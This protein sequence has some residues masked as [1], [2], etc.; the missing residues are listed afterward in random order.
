MEQNTT[1]ENIK[2]AHFRRIIR[3]FTILLIVAFLLLTAGL[4]VYSF[5]A[6]DREFSDSENRVLA[7]MPQITFSNIVSGKFMKDFESYLADQFPFR[8][9][10]ISIK[11]FADRVLSKRQENGVFIGD[12]NFL[13][14]DQ[15]PYVEADNKEKVKLIGEFSKK[16]KDTKQMMVI[17]PNSSYIYSEYLPYDKQLYDQSDV[18][19]KVYS[20]VKAPKMHKLDA[21]S[22]LQD[23]KESGVQLFYK[24]DHH[25]TT[26]GAYSVFSEIAEHWELEGDD[27]FH[28]FYPVSSDFEGTLSSKAGVHDFKDTVEICVPE[29]AGGSYVVSY[30]S[31]QKKTSSLF[32]KEKLE[33]KNKYEVFLGGNYDKVI[34]TTLSP[35]RNTLLI[36]KDSYANCMIPMFTPFFSK[37]IIVDPRYM[38]ESIHSVMGEHD[39]THVLFLYN[40]NTFL[41]DTSI[42][43]VFK[44]DK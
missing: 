5:V 10:A 42:V 18:I 1:K 24:T 16:Y 28:S 29:K 21:V 9:E 30:E 8:D 34:V 22:I 25:W 33:E 36:V 40:L 31:Q 13:F 43:P 15:I 44:E 23:E 7:S 32:D 26:R 38:T 3:A 11:T 35:D 6:K 27:V 19:E 37:I 41:E 39:V 14:D 20:S 17:S 4:G 2:A 12:E